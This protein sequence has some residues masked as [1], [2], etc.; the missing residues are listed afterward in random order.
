MLKTLELG[1]SQQVDASVIWLHGLGADGHDFASAVTALALPAV[2]FILPHAPYQA[3]TIN[4]GHEM[5]AWYD[6]YSLTPGSREDEIGIRQ[7]Q[8]ALEALIAAEQARGISSERIVLA[9]FSQGGAIALHTALRH[10]APLAG[11]L[12][13][14]SYLPLKAC[15]AAEA[16]AVNRQLPIFVA[17]GSFDTVIPPAVAQY[18]VELLRAQHYAP[19]WH[20]YPMAHSVCHAELQDIR[21]FLTTILALPQ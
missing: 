18:S 9:G 21:T 8:T 19:E 7:S 2:R 13:L 14:S 10:A 15:L 5:R 4:N 20:E 1:N 11:V 3:V 17:H 16:H 6:I 12:V